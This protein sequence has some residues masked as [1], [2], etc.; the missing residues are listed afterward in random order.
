VIAY[1]DDFGLRRWGFGVGI[2]VPPA[3]SLAW[4][5]EV[6]G[7]P[8]P[9]RYS[10][11]DTKGSAIGS[12]VLA[13]A[14]R[15][16]ERLSLGAAL[17]ITTAQVAGKVAISACDY[18][19]CSQPEAPEWEGTSSF[20]LGPVVTASAT[21]GARWDFDHARI[22]GSVQL[23]TKIKGDAEFKIAL[24]DQSIFDGVT[25]ENED[26]GSDLH[27]KMEV[28]LPTIIRLGVEG[29][30]ERNTKVELGGTWENWGVQRSIAVR[31]IGVIA[32]EVPGIGD[33]Q[34]EPVTLTTNMRPTWALNLGG[35]HDFSRYLHG[36]KLFGNAGFMY[37][38]SSLSTRDL[39]PTTIDTNKV[40]LAAGASFEVVR[41]MLLD[42]SYGHVFMVDHVVRDSRVLLPAAI[43]PLPADP[44]PGMFAAGDRPAIGNGRYNIE[45]DVVAIGLR[46]K[47][48]ET[49][50]YWRSKSSG[51]PAPA[52]GAAPA[53]PAPAA[54]PA[55]PAAA[56]ASVQPAPAAAPAQPAPAAPAPAAAPVPPAP[57]SPVPPAPAAAPE[58]PAPAAPAP[59][60]QPQ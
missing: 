35:T 2:I 11:L 50:A 60:A 16:L 53:Q 8:A 56:A 20:L 38:S 18:A 51:G 17:Y 52:A 22:G 7:A 27:A 14:Y 24:P 44:D 45:A 30:V 23:R 37:E 34:A 57:G 40:L 32:R 28:A 10:I 41:G 29:D 31:P 47:I 6:D 58:T 39:S 46:W 19:V 33:V 4:P 42:L 25:V 59:P 15:P 43:R 3:Y 48:E 26:G 36:R 54:A 9:Q 49:R 13:A 5:S 55:Q 1:S 21:F 12:F